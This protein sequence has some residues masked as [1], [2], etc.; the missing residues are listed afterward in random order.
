MK[1]KFLEDM[2]LSKEQV[3]AILD[4][5]SQ[6]IGKAK[7]EFTS[8]QTELQN[9]KTEI[10]GLNN[11]L[12]ERDTQLS[13][14]KNSTGD[15]EALKQQ[16]SDLQTANKTKEDEHKA[17][18]KQL[19]MDMAVETALIGAKAKNIK[20]VKALLNLEGAELG[21]DGTVKGLAEQILSLSKADDSKLL[22]DSA[23][24]IVKGAKIGEGSDDIIE[25]GDTSKMSYSQM[26]AYLKENPDAKIN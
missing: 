18:M 1:R 21:E 24:T 25:G 8:I 4:E 11:Q 13:E 7:A 17:E 16:I 22:F 15:V 9:A 20:A 3:D 6:D 10:E 19:K 5:N 12:S 2:G 23:K 26:V 14:L